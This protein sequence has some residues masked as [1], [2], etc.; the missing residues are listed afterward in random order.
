MLQQITKQ[1]TQLS[2]TSNYK[3]TSRPVLNQPETNT[4]KARIDHPADPSFLNE[5]H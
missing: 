2:N 5:A 1:H 3:M 4:G